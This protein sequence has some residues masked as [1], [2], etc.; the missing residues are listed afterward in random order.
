WGFQF[1]GHHVNLNCFVLGDQV[2]LTP[3]FLGSEPVIA[4][5]G[6]YAGTAVFRDEER[7][8]SALLESLSDDERKVAVIADELPREMFSA[9]FRDN[10]ELEYSGIAYEALSGDAKGR[11]LE[12]IEVYC[13]RIRPGHA[14]VKMAEIREHLDETYFCWMGG[15]G[16]EDVFYY[17]V[18]SP[19][20]LIEFDHQ[21]GVVYDNDY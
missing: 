3:L 1:D 12:L 8:G 15:T 18:H 21:S 11:L 9:A 7:V 4:D 5:S 2:V 6:T 14:E 16:A 17:R 19:V 20:I 13:G 10:I